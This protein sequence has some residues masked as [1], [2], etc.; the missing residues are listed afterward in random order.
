MYPNPATSGGLVSIALD[1][2]KAKIKKAELIGIDGKS[3]EILFNNY[4]EGTRESPFMFY[5]PSVAVGEYIVKFTDEKNAVYR[6]KILI[7]K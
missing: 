1:E 5:L 2:I 7:T 3:T 6:Q 4:F